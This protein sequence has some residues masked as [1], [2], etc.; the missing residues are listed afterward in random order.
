MFVDKVKLEN[1]QGIQRESREIQI[2][3]KEG[4]EKK[5]KKGKKS[6]TN[7]LEKELFKI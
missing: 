1:E 2:P 6:N 5:G 3:K 4:N 7:M